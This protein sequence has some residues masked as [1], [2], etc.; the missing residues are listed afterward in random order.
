MIGRR[1]FLQGFA[2]AGLAATT[3]CVTR[4]TSPGVV[5]VGGGFGGASAVRTL[6]K[7]DPT[8][9]V[10]LI[11]PRSN[12]VSCP[13]SNL[14]LGGYRD[15]SEQTFGYDSLERQ[16]IKRIPASAVGIDPITRR[17]E[18]DVG[19]FVA[20]ERLILS[21]GIS[22]HYEALDGYSEQAALQMPHAWQ[23]GEQT[24]L[25]RKQLEAMEDGGVVAISVP[26]NPYRCPPGPY[27]RASLIANYLKKHK[28]R[29]KVLLLD[30][31]DRFS[32]QSLFM[33]GWQQT[34]G[35]MVQ[36]Q[37]FSDGAAVVSVDATSKTLR[38]DFDVIKADVANV[39]PPQRAG[40]IAL[41]S[42]IADR[43]GWCPVDAMS[44][45][46]TIAPGVHV[47]G[48]A[49]ILNAMPKSAF[50]ANAQAKLCATQI[51]RLM[52]GLPPLDVTLANTCYSLIDPDYGISVAG[53]Y[54]AEETRWVSVPG[55]GGT[56]YR[57]ADGSVRR[58][59]ARYAEDWFKAITE[60]AFL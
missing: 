35:Q 11:E 15:I 1:S 49:A 9:P 51:I 39:I 22:I 52:K 25:L 18:L 17:V 47:I 12:Y 43:T 26:E 10:T 50:A 57:G 19:G 30:A 38:T 21:P 40:K 36:W 32:K 24:V 33:D 46:S 8:L 37:G 59:E 5:V 2:A 31:K 34:S 13:F 23:A 29:S 28:P 16:E 58:L 55:S 6:R 14:V 45:E 48:D 20:Y 44:F 56:S 42:G 7:L 54:R 41:T 53:V 60:E 27:E 3:G 4:S